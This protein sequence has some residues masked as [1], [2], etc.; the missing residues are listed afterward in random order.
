MP[1]I[2]LWISLYFMVAFSASDCSTIFSRLGR[3]G[4]VEQIPSMKVLFE[5]NAKSH[6]HP[7]II[8]KQDT[9]GKQKKIELI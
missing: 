9:I 7:G 2:D 1:L 4:I 3:R 8:R 5:T 6:K